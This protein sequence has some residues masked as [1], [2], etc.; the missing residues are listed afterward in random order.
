MQFDYIVVGAGSAGSIVAAKLAETRRFKVLLLEAGP[1]DR[2][3]FIQ[4]PLGY[5]MSFFNPKLNW[6][7][8]S[9]PVPALDGRSVYVPRGKVVGG[10]SS[11]NAMVYV[12]GQAADYDDWEAAGATG[13]GWRAV[14]PAYAAMEAAGLPFSSMRDGAHPLCERYF[15]ASAA[16]GIRRND[17]FEPQSQ[18]GVGFYPV[19]ISQGRRL[20][21]SR[22]FLWQ[23]M[24]ASDRLQVFTGALATKILFD[25]RRA[26]GVEYTRFG[27]PQKAYAAKEVILA[28][29]AINTPQLLQLSG[30]GP[31]ELLRRHGIDVVQDMPAVGRHLQD[32]ASVDYYYRATV[33]TQNQQLRPFF[34]KAWAGL[35]YALTRSGPLAW[36]LNQSGG[37]IRSNPSRARPNIQVYFCPSSYEKSPPRTRKM[38]QPDPFPG[39]CISA[40]SC[41]PT[42]RGFVEIV[43]ANPGDAP[44]IQPNLLATP[45]DM[46]E[47]VEG[48][49]HLRALVRAKPLASVIA[50]EFKPGPSVETD[51]QIEADIRARAYSIFHPCGSAR[52]GSDPASSVVDPNLKVHGIGGLR[53][54]DAS[55]FPTV[56]AGNTNA[57]SMLVG[58]CGA[59][60]ILAG[61]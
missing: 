52:I 14:G 13:W 43:S 60:R 61:S 41:R 7:Y 19:T 2:S 48:V 32:H 50:E 44:S 38:T 8:W 34:G 26:T 5:G 59:Q 9:A 28:G 56:I 45:E 46:Q 25:G 31:A 3:F 15:E 57:P 42:S 54:I 27:A 16:L 53:V 47:M 22:A 1:S 21:A 17:E 58:W 11:I 18:E 24:K 20:S 12:R 30:L 55:V 4:M 49:R 51:A 37:F 10:S 35:R 6:M 33:P 29:G 39:I 23:A 36:S 40:C